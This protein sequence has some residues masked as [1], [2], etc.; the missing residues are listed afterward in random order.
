[1][2]PL[3][4]LPGTEMAT[5]DSRQHFGIVTR[6][7]ILPQCHGV[8]RFLDQPFPSAEV[9]ELVVATDSMSF[10]DYLAA[11]RFELSVEIFYNDVYLEEVH[12][13]V[14]AL[15][16]SMFDFV[17]R[18]HARY[19][20]FPAELRELYDSLENAT[21]DNLWEDR[22]A[23]LEHFRNRE[24]L[25]R[26]A[27]AEYRNSLGIMKAL[28]LL[29]HI[30]PVLAIARAALQDCLVEAGLDRPSRSRYV[31]ELLHYSLLRRQDL[32]DAGQQPEGTFGF[33]FDRIRERGFRVDPDEFELAEPRRMHFWHDDGQ[34]RDIRELCMEAPHP[35]LRARSVIYPKTDPGVNPYLR[36]SA[37]R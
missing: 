5:P 10:D 36:R 22:D 32:L 33:A 26:H 29:D 17:E 30:G 25:E 27:A 24:E 6:F 9:T 8:Y 28:A 14:R 2:Y 15:G 35:V 37:F 4:L 13:L 23:C 11:R 3:A 34:T 19:G 16:L 20:E 21:R 31:D 7:R 1:M 12:G 18:C